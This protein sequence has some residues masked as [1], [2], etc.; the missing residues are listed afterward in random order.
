[1]N[2]KLSAKFQPSVT[3]SCGEGRPACRTGRGEVALNS[4]KITS[5]FLFL[6]LTIGA[7][8]ANA[9]DYKKQYR[10]AK[11]LFD[12]AK[13]S[14]AMHA[15]KSLTVYDRDN[16]FSEYASFYYA[17]SAY[18]LGYATVAKDMLLQIKSLYPQWEQLDE[19]NY[20]LC[21]IYFDQKEYFQ[22][23][24]LLDQVRGTSFQ[25]DLQN[26]KL[27]YISQIEDAET[28]HMMLEEHP[29]D[30]VVAKI[31]VKRLGQQA[32]HLQ[33]TLL[34]DSLI[35]HFYFSKEELIS[36]KVVRPLKKDTVRVALILPFL[37]ATLEP[38]PVKKRNQIIL[39]LYQGMKL[40]ADT[41]SKSGIQLK[42]MAYDNE[43]NV[44]STR[45]IVNE[46]ELRQSDLLV[47][48]F[49][50]EEAKPI[51]DF[52]MSN[53]INVIVSP[54][55]NNS[56]FVHQN[57]YSFLFQPS[58][59]SIGRSSAELALRMTRK[60][61]CF[62]YYGETVKDSVMAANFIARASELE[63]K[64]LHAQRI[65]RESSGSIL[66]KLASATE[67]DEWKNPLQFSLKK[68]S[69]GCIFVASS[70][71]LIYSKVINSVET[72]GDS[73]LV[74]G[75]E[76]WLD[77]SS[78]DFARFERIRIAL[79]APNFRSLAN[80]AFHHFRVRYINRHGVLP[81]EYACVG[82]EFIM[83]M[84]QLMDR[85]GVNFLQTI[86]E[87]NFVQ[88]PMSIGLSLSPQRDNRLVPFVSFKSG[89]LVKVD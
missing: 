50:Q 72:R 82:Y 75:Q 41:L 73:I 22:A 40:A 43:R 68:D 77:E 51:L 12:A 62:V 23:R 59:E 37:A 86:D 56:D 70:N 52:S 7:F 33:D 10:T 24:L 61:N 71:E 57:P 15:F 11:E 63:I 64:V 38:S 31:L 80:P 42:L 30:A 65:T 5:W 8:T 9:Q 88:G 45:K 49:F 28:L 79:A 81:T 66:S 36:K 67:Y 89:K 39:E 26:L 18:R 54:L 25:E 3:L 29:D 17:M 87:G 46:E 44:A 74:I 2:L 19:V 76:E 16:Q 78:V 83:V 69:I 35:N 53:Q 27:A 4:R 13:Y 60:K 34:I 14:E 55:S 48:P 20:T 58:H 85:Y 6:C 84:G 21:K 32:Y 47:G 1:M